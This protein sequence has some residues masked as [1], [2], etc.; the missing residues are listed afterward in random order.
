MIKDA[1]ERP[2]FLPPYS[3]D[4]TPIIKMVFLIGTP[5]RRADERMRCLDRAGHC[6]AWVQNALASDHGTV[7]GTNRKSLAMSEN[8]VLLRTN[9]RLPPNSNGKTIP[10]SWLQGHRP[11]AVESTGAVPWHRAIPKFSQEASK[12]LYARPCCRYRFPTF[13]T[14]SRRNRKRRRLRQPDDHPAFG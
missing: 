9:R 3:P 2:I 13:T 5:L 1:G 8:R 6:P 7:P 14:I 11:M 12:A 4:L 10:S